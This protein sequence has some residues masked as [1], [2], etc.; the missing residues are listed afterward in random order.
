MTLESAL[1][2]VESAGGR[3]RIVDGGLHV[4]VDIELPE[5]VWQTLKRHRDEIIATL[6]G[7]GPIWPEH[8]PP[9]WPDRFGHGDRLPAPA[10]VECC[11]RCR[12]TE[13]IDTAIHGGRSIRRD[14]AV[15]GRFRKFTIWNGDPMP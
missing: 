11:D 14:C 12:S 7:D 15:C 3:M 1:L 2:A 13:T 4:D 10:G 9:I 8:A 6:A 5:P